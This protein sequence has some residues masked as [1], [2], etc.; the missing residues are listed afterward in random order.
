MPSPKKASPAHGAEAEMSSKK[1][2]ASPAKGAGKAQGEKSP[3]MTKQ[4]PKNK[5]KA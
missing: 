3:Q 2:V 4:R 5:S 1:K